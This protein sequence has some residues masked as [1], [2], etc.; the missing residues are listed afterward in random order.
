MVVDLLII[1]NPDIFGGGVVFGHCFYNAV[2]SALSSFE[3]FSPRKRWLVAKNTYLPE[4][5]I[6]MLT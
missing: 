2:L 6:A 3:K 4:L 5:Y 1:V